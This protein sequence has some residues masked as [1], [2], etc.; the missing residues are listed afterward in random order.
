MYDVAIVGGGVTGC[1]CAFELSSHGY[2]CILLEK[3]DDL[4]SE[5]SSGNRS[6]TVCMIEPTS[7]IAS[8]GAD[9]L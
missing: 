8:N 3:N 5:A 2:T 7:L 1:A 4:V 6:V 9:L